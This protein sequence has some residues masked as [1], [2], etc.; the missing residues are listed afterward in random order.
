MSSESNTS[1][2]M[3]FRR[4]SCGLLNHERT[5]DGKKYYYLF[6]GLGSIVGMTDSAGNEVNRYVYDPYGNIIS[7]QEQ[8]GL[9]NPWKFAAGYLD[10]STN[11][12]KFGTRY[13]DPTLGRWTQQDP[14]GGSL[15]DLNSANRYTYANDDPVNAVDPSGKDIIGCTLAVLLVALGFAAGIAAVV[16]AVA[17]APEVLATGAVAAASVGATVGTYSALIGG[18]IAIIAAWVGVIQ[19]AVSG[20]CS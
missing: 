18:G 17:T 13:Y 16:G 20:V 3:Y 15:G 10:S 6:D 5:P 1:G 14:V 7:Q 9:N 8:S 4:C 12:Y 11:L 2:T 19:T